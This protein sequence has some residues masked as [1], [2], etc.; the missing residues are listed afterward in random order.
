M[1]LD[2]YSEDG[3]LLKDSNVNKMHVL[4]KEACKKIG[5]TTTPGVHLEK[6]ANEAGFKNIQHS[7][8]KIPLGTWPK[9]RKFVGRPQFE[10]IFINALHLFDYDV[11]TDTTYY[12]E[13]N[14]GVQFDPV[15]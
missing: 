14:R 7:V 13:R 4:L 9:D 3:T 5:R 12:I 10:I 11:H 1:E 6:W 8:Y 15:P 2:V